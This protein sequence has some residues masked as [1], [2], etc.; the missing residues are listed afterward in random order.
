LG[1]YGPFPFYKPD[2]WIYEKVLGDE[3]QALIEK[4]G[5]IESIDDMDLGQ[6]RYALAEKLNVE[7][8][9]EQ[10]VLY[11]QHPNDAVSF[12]KFEEEFGKA[13]VLP[14]SIFFRKGG[15]DI[16]E[17]LAFKD[18]DGKEHL[19]EI[20]PSPM[21]D[22]GET[23][24]YLTVDHHPSVF[25]FTSVT[26]KTAPGKEVKLSKE[27]IMDLA[28]AGDVR[29]PFAAAIV[30]ISVKDGQEV[31]KGDR[32]AVMEAMKMQTPLL[33]EING[34]VTA[35]YAKPGSKLGPGDK[36]LKIDKEE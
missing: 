32:V 16:G 17:K 7:P 30:E 33:S 15:F 24:V 14:P 28:L 9:D 6:E 21:T 1:K 12:F 8:T 18:I 36:I 2:L 34:I 31:M 23:L 13:H 26:D 20:G 5:G 25:A 4:E 22:D 27:E 10:L 3:W 11:L 19:I 29:S 35:I